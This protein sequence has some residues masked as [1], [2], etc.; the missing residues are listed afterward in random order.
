MG[1]PLCR[2]R[3]AALVL[4]LLGT[5]P[6]RGASAACTAVTP[7][8]CPNCFAV[9]V[10][11]DTQGYVNAPYQPK[12]A[13]HLDLVTRYICD[14]RSSWTEPSTGKQMPIAMVIQLGDLV[15]HGD[16]AG[17]AAEWA[18]ADAAFD[19]LDACAAPVPYLVTLGNHDINGLY[20]STTNGYQ[21]YFGTDRWTSQGYGCSALGSCD[22]SAGEWFIGGGDPIAAGSRNHVGDGSPGPA[23]SQAG[24]HRAARIVAPNGQPFLFLGLELAFDFPP[25]APGFEAV[26]G[27]DGAWPL[28]VLAAHPGIATVVFH[29]SLLWAFP[30]PDTRLRWGPEVWHSDSIPE[31]PG[32]PSDPDYGLSGGMEAVYQRLIEP[33]SQVRFLFTGHVLQPRWIADYTIDRGGRPPVFALLRNFQNRTLAA[34]PSFNYGVGWNVIA[35]FDPDAQQVRVRSYRIDDLEAYATSPTN[36]DH[37]G[38]PAPTE[39]FDKDLAGVPER[40]IDWDFQVGSGAVPA[41]APL[42]LGGLGALLV[43]APAFWLRP[44]RRVRDAAGR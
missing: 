41:L 19:N 29:H 24:R 5:L 21:T 13:S 37:T 28:Q 38:Q 4:A 15:Q 10:M 16:G 9:F 6:A 7:V 33:F 8:A 22:W 17:S 40:V 25:P 36:L 39:C 43:L 34:D 18:I 35:V 11:P 14:Q 2:A 32:D 3:V 12:G 1:P 42:S 23:T 27:D 20:E 31:P 44:S 26:E 30:L